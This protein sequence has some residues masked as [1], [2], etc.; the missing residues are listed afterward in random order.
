MVFVFN[1]MRFSKPRT[2]LSHYASQF[3]DKWEAQCTGPYMARPHNWRGS[4]VG[5]AQPACWTQR[6]SPPWPGNVAALGLRGWSRWGVQENGEGVTADPRLEPATTLSDAHFSFC[7]GNLYSASKASLRKGSRGKQQSPLQRTHCTSGMCCR[8]TGLSV[9]GQ[10]L[11]FVKPG[12]GD[13][14]GQTTI[15]KRTQDEARRGSGEGGNLAV[16]SVLSLDHHQ[17]CD[18]IGGKLCGP[19]LP[20]ALDF[21]AQTHKRIYWGKKGP[22]GPP[23]RPPPPPIVGWGHTEESL[24]QDFTLG[25]QT[26]T[27]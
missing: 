14:E 6:P 24:Q 21:T 12:A 13:S 16:L 26:Q 3:A 4:R 11:P 10:G 17:P 19:K 27:W 9:N 7:F 15:R 22:P 2:Q 20:P 18:G 25:L 23:Q 5:S 1:G 8:S